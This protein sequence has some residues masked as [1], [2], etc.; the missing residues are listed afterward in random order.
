MTLK[1]ISFFRF[2]PVSGV[3]IEKVSGGVL[4]FIERHSQTYEHYA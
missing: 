4:N 1:K 3:K 2:Q